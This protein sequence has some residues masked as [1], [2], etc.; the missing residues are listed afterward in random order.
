MPKP[1]RNGGKAMLS[2]NIEGLRSAVKAKGTI[3]KTSDKDRGWIVE[4]AIPF[5]SIYIGNHWRPPRDGALWRINFSRVQWET[6]IVNNTYVKKKDLP[7]HN[8]VWSPQGLINMHYPE[9]WGYLLFT[10]DSNS[11]TVFVLPQD[12]QR[13]QYLW[14]IYYKQKAFFEKNRRYA[15]SLRE[16]GINEGTVNVGGTANRLSMEAT[17]RQFSACITDG[18][19]AIFVNDEG[20]IK[21]VK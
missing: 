14:L 3:N 6:E 9:R 15:P 7:E 8:W 11:R 21:Q 5:R 10:K 19:S 2:Y 18:N 1:Y 12:E 4:M 16:L 17:T 20:F 13:R